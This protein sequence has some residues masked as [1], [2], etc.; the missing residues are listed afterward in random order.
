M[1]SIPFVQ[2][3]F[4][5]NFEVQVKM[6]KPWDFS[7]LRVRHQLEILIVLTLQGLG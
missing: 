1:K 7:F 5:R 4:Q 2:V 6:D 3:A